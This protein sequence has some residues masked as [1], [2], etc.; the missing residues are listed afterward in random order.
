MSE[1]IDI[2]PGN[3]TTQSE[4]S[5]YDATLTQ[6]VAFKNP[7]LSCSLR[8]YQLMGYPEQRLIDSS[9][10]TVADS[11][12][13]HVLAEAKLGKTCRCCY[14]VAQSC[15]PPCDPMDSSLLGPSV[16]GISQ[17]RILEWVAD[18]F[19][20]GSSRTSDQTCISHISRGV[21]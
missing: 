4:K 12:L 5:P 7:S 14:L 10:G 20:T 8:K 1:V 2:S 3:T 15:L 18:A 19:S 6:N 21:L 13:L 16:H 11:S 9:L 17:A